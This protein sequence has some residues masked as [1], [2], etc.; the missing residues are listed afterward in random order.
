M[1]NLFKYLLSK[2]TNTWLLAYL[3]LFCRIIW[4]NFWIFCLAFEAAH[5]A[6]VCLMPLP[7]CQM[8]GPGKPKEVSHREYWDRSSW[9]RPACHH[10]CPLL[11]Q[12]DCEC[13]FAGNG[14]DPCFTC[15][16]FGKEWIV[17]FAGVLFRC[18]EPRESKLDHCLPFLHHFHPSKHAYFTR[19]C[20]IWA[21]LFNFP[22][23]L[24]YRICYCFVALRGG[25]IS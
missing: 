6:S 3:D 9:H 8:S 21:H 22:L 18:R 24:K 25:Q 7:M 10:P 15:G 11:H 16:G 17:L 1:I 23:D 4:L 20:L 5:S 2:P 13:A 14:C 19:N 12:N